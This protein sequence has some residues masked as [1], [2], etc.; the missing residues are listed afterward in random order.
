MVLQ[1]GKKWSRFGSANQDP[2]DVA[3][4]VPTSG[5]EL[6]ACVEAIRAAGIPQSAENYMRDAW[7]LHES[8]PEASAM[9][10]QAFKRSPGDRSG[11]EQAIIVA[12]TMNEYG[13]TSEYVARGSQIICGSA[14]AGGA[15]IGEYE[16][17]DWL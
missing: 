3:D 11:A 17:H 16:P 15:E 14:P 1:S 13:G 8:F 6:K 5:A 9:L 4:W 2:F 12:R 10:W 7:S